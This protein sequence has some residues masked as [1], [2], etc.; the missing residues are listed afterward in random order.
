M[1]G[2]GVGGLNVGAAA[3]SGALTYDVDAEAFGYEAVAD[4][5]GV[6][7]YLNGDD[8]DML[9]NVGG[10]YEYG[11]G[12]A[13]LSAGVNYNIDTEDFAPTAGIAFKF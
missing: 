8:T 2:A 1:L 5:Y 7:A 9:Q 13:V 3:L 11:L 10:S 12:G 4:A 6:T